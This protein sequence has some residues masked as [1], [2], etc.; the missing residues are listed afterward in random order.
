MEGPMTSTPQQEEQQERE[1]LKE[2]KI[3]EEQKD[4]PAVKQQT[5]GKDS[6]LKDLKEAIQGK[7]VKESRWDKMEGKTVEVK[8][9][10]REREE[11]DEQTDEQTDQEATLD[12]E[13]TDTT[14]A[15]PQET[16]YVI[17]ISPGDI[18][19][20]DTTDQQ[21]EE[22]DETA[23][24]EDEDS[25]EE[26]DVTDCNVTVHNETDSSQK[27]LDSIVHVEPGTSLEE[28]KE[29]YDTEKPVDV[30][31]DHDVTGSEQNETHKE[32]PATL[33]VMCD[34]VR[35]R[36]STPDCIPQ[37]KASSSS[38]D[39]EELI[40]IGNRHRIVQQPDMVQQE[41]RISKEEQHIV[42]CDMPHKEH[43]NVVQK[44]HD[45]PQ[46]ADV[47]P[48]LD[49]SPEPNISQE[50]GDILQ[51]TEGH[52]MEKQ[53]NIQTDPDDIPTDYPCV[54]GEPTGGD[55]DGVV[56]GRA[57]LWGQ[58]EAP[59]PQHDSIKQERCDVYQMKEN[60]LCAVA[61]KEHDLSV[62]EA[63]DTK[64]EDI[65]TLRD[66]NDEV[67]SQEQAQNP[68]NTMKEQEQNVIATQGEGDVINQ[69][70]Q[71]TADKHDVLEH[72]QST[73]PQ[74]ECIMEQDG[75]PSDRIIEH[76]ETDNKEQE[77]VTGH[78]V[79]QEHVS[80]QQDHVGEQQDIAVQQDH[81]AMQQD[82]VGEQQDVAM[83]QEHVAM[84][85]EHVPVQQDC[86]VKEQ[87]YDNM[88]QGDVA[89]QQDDIVVQ[90]DH[91]TMQSGRVAMQEE[92][93]AMQQDH[94]DK[95]QEHIAM[96]QGNVSM[97]QDHVTMQSEYD[98][99]WYDNDDDDTVN[100]PPD[101]EQQEDIIQENDNTVWK[102]QDCVQNNLVEN[103]STITS[104][105][106]DVQEAGEQLDEDKTE[107]TGGEEQPLE[108]E[109]MD[110]NTSSQS[111]TTESLGNPH[112]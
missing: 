79:Q 85:Q 21:E 18:T 106:A 20:G 81:V 61:E 87:E 76:Q 60:D 15:P 30:M 38:S 63:S 31:V 47:T 9:D 94:V 50:E 26:I 42:S 14:D 29:T 35:E 104:K 83:K 78:A 69:E 54:H 92:D 71:D 19:E 13:D 55:D 109:S 46:G 111:E 98:T 51:E 110:A 39:D 16:V 72:E 5:E 86:V 45:I 24:K 2:I 65:T 7:G 57:T 90:Q 8:E 64:V 73:D 44:E 100:K 88:Q 82:H 33:E 105:E 27:P 28:H 77:E 107:V 95:Q 4:K 101:T 1:V 49:V 70:V 25:Q 23:A 112:R 56:E 93:V 52:K 66:S 103:T 91:V 36:D 99:T 67:T 34:L 53:D 3:S 84:Q 59:Q 10:A 102:E 96:Q 58:Q 62:K 48:K 40:T 12:A 32:P 68:S 6:E 17:M 89:M 74:P 97:Q 22:R 108:D 80:V 41:C 11:T 37:H 43:N 75:M